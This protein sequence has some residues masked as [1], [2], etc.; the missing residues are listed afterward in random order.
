MRVNSLVTKE[1][2]VAYLTG[3]YT[4]G[5]GRYSVYMDTSTWR[6]SDDLLLLSSSQKAIHSRTLRWGILVPSQSWIWELCWRD[7]DAR[8]YS[9]LCTGMN[10]QLIHTLS[11]QTRLPCLSAMNAKAAFVYTAW[12]EISYPLRLSLSSREQRT[13]TVCCFRS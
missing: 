1:G 12:T 6:S 2:Q 11:R 13:K 7:E 3:T 4:K 8:P 9:Y 5:T 10:S